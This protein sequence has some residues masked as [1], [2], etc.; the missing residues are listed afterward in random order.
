MRVLSPPT[1]DARGVSYARA[2]R[3]LNE[4]EAK[5]GAGA[6]AARAC[7]GD[8]ASADSATA[9]MHGDCETPSADIAGTRLAVDALTV[10]RHE[11]RVQRRPRPLRV[12]IA[13][14]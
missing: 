3:V 11:N 9:G 4:N 10:W 2:P 1:H 6:T 13:V 8:D 14:V 5:R 7:H 12:A